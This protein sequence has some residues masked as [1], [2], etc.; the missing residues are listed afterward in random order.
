MLNWEKTLEILRQQGWGYGYGKC[1]DEK[2]G[3]DLFLV[4]LS[5]GDLRLTIFKPSIEEAVSALRMLAGN[6]P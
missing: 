2:T 3:E 4:N 5:R 6:G 1:Q